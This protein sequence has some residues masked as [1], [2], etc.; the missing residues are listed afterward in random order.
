[1]ENFIAMFNEYFS[2]YNN[3]DKQIFLILLSKYS[4]RYDNDSKDDIIPEHVEIYE[5]CNNTLFDYVMKKY[6]CSCKNKLKM[7]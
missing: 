7:Y 4:L 1:M 5:F 2:K 3:V 6:Y